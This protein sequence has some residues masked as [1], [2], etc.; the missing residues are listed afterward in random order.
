MAPYILISCVERE[1]NIAGAFYTFEEAQNKMMREFKE[2][3][4]YDSSHEFSIDEI[5]DLESNNAGFNE[6]SAWCESANHDNC[7]WKIFEI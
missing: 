4:G 5:D 7:D 2:T 3:L 1:I 6:D